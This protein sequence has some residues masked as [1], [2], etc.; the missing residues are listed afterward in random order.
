MAAVMDFALALRP[1]MQC[2]LTGGPEIETTKN[3]ER[4]DLWLRLS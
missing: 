3:I 1:C 2:K 4:D